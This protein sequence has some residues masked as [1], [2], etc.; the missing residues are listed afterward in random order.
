MKKDFTRDYATSAFRMWARHG[1]PTYDEAV[2]KIKS[3]AMSQAGDVDRL[4]KIA[5]AE[6][7]VEK[8][9]ALLCDVLACERTFIS[10]EGHGKKHVCDAVRAVYMVDPWREARR[11]ELTS[12]VIRYSMRAHISESQVYRYLREA[13][14][15]FC[16]LRGLRISD[17]E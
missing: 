3:R 14:L 17:E 1:C 2:D 4:K 9:T 13:R 6:S 10:L 8:R 5:F 15:F 11:G 16:G 12:R 7:E